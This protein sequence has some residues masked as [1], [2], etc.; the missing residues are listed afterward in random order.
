[1]T[2]VTTK[3]NTQ[4]ARLY[5]PPPRYGDPG[6][7]SAPVSRVS[8]SNNELTCGLYSQYFHLLGS[9]ALSTIYSSQR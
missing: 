9:S 7:Y 4:L 3:Q 6:V 5:D 1:M 8:G 2:L